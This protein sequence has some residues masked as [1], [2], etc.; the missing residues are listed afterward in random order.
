[1]V[2]LLILDDVVGEALVDEAGVRIEVAQYL[3]V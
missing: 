1:V 2:P 3:I